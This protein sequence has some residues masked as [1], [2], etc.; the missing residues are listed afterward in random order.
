MEQLYTAVWTAEE[1]GK[2]LYYLLARKNIDNIYD[3]ELLRED[4]LGENTL[5]DNRELIETILKDAI[6][7]DYKIITKEEAQLILAEHKLKYA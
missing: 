4:Y 6:A 7:K 5:Y 3:G 1:Q 2:T